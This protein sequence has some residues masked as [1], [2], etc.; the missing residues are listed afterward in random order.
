MYVFDSCSLESPLKVNYL[1][2][3]AM[4]ISWWNLE[5]VHWGWHRS[6]TT[7]SLPNEDGVSLL[8][9]RKLSRRSP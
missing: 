8:L 5:T 4:E 2:L 7:N 1:H 6:N 9:L 3:D